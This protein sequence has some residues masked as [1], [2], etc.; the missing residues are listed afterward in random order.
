MLVCATGIV[1]AQQDSIPQIVE[2][3][4]KKYVQHIV[5]QGNTLYAISKRYNTPIDVIKKSNPGLD[6]GL[7]IGQTILIPLKRDAKEAIN[8][9]Q[10]EI[11]GNYLI[12]EVRQGERI[13]K[14]AGKEVR[15]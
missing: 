13:L 5:E 1:Q 8:N 14:L 2:I 7:S 6:Q 10:V 12:H 4:K 11:D 3:N 9:Q 15:A